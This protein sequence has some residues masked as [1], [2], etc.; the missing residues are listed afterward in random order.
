M[1]V[2]SKFKCN[3][4]ATGKCT[5][6]LTSRQLL[7]NLFPNKKWN[8]NWARSTSAFIP[9]KNPSV[10][11]QFRSQIQLG[12]S[13]R[14][15]FKLLSTA[16]SAERLNLEEELIDESSGN[17]TT[18]QSQ[19][20]I[21]SKPKVGGTWDPSNPV[22][23]AK[24]FGRRDPSKE[25]ELLKKAQLKAGDEGYFDVSS[26]TVT[27]VTM[28]RTV[29]DARKVMKRLMSP[30]SQQIFHACDTEVMDIDLKN[31][32][33]VGNGF[34]TCASIYSGPNFDYGLG[35]GPGTALWIDNLDESFGV[36]QEFKEFFED[37]R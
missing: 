33:P 16:S 31:V 2:M 14:Y 9:V 17:G 22:D 5:F 18:S 13:H 27:G 15:Q 1:F 20:K 19:F 21:K 8:Q 29:Q 26:I 37:E 4:F 25:A 23:W 3:A 32:G 7:T 35:D 30:E 36:L 10:G 12:V 28:V 11:S 34:V 6:S 24:D